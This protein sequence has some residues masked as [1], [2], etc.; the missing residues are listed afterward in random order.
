[1]ELYILSY[2]A[3]E[4]RN[5]PP[6]SNGTQG[7]IVYIEPSEYGAIDIHSLCFAQILL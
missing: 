1:M 5:R 3:R 2:K 6:E 4:H 7:F